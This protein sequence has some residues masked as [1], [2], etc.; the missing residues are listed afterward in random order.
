MNTKNAERWLLVAMFAGL[1]CG[2][3]GSGSA[4]ADDTASIDDPV[5]VLASGACGPDSC[6]T[7][8]GTTTSLEPRRVD[9]RSQGIELEGF[10]YPFQHREAI[11]VPGGES[12]TLTRYT[13]DAGGELVRGRT[14]SFAGVGYSGVI[15]AGRARIVSD[16]K[17]YAFDEANGVI[18]VWNPSKMELTGE[19][20]DISLIHRDRQDAFV[21]AWENGAR[22]LGD[23]LFVPVGWSDS[24]TYAYRPVSGML[25]IDTVRDEVVKLL[26]DPRCPELESSIV[27]ADGDIYYG[28]PSAAG[29]LDVSAQDPSFP[30]CSLRIRAG[31]TEFDSDYF[32]NVSELTGGRIGCCAAS[33]GGN[34]AYVQVLHEERTGIT[35]R[36]ELFGSAHNDWRL[37]RVDLE[38]QHADEVTALPW[39]AT[40]GVTVFET[41][42]AVLQPI[43]TLAGEV[44]GLFSNAERWTTL[45][46]LTSQ[47]D[48]TPTLSVDGNLL[49]FARIR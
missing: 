41:P 24:E 38:A 9:V 15:T 43:L 29:M 16:E 6:Q 42:E 44:G 18:F 37:W 36:V 11:I 46:D 8:L 35:D 21:S 28:F 27:T 31:E 12:P 4:A 22:Q 20:I 32:L 45:V 47:E 17:A 10:V 5:Y 39:F 19:E 33:G 48:P 40:S 7:Y 14:L 30:A 23:L 2:C 3:G 25:I 26:E 1:G 49:F 13:V 34:T